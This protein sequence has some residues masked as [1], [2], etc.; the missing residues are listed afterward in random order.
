MSLT[1]GRGPHSA[2]PAG[3]FSSPVPSPVTYVEPF[4]R[5]VRAR[6]GG[7]V[8]VDSERVL[9]VHVPGQPPAYAFPAADVRLPGG[10]PE[11]AAPGHVRVPWDA[12]D[13]WYEEE[14]RMLGHPRNPYHRIDCLRSTR[15]LHV[16]VAGRVLVD[17]SDTVALYETALAPR[18]YVHPDQVDRTILRPS[19]TT[20]YCPYKGTASY[21]TAVVDGVVVEDVAWSY[22]D[23]LPESS[24]IAGLLG[25]DEGRATVEAELPAPSRAL[26]GG[27]SG[28][29]SGDEE[30]SSG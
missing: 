11:P 1:T 19:P 29:L 25:F 2:R 18:L 5:R 17:T 23:P 9:L 16:S 21:W 24:Q 10:E 22:E 6:A 4:Q 20:T 26:D 13:E 15:R 28:D 30:P 12:V 8:V 14:E 3:R 7:S 27:L